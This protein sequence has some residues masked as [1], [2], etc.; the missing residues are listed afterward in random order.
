MGTDGETLTLGRA[1]GRALFLRC[2]R[3]GKGRIYAGW[4]AMNPQCDSC[5]LEFEREQGYYVGAMYVNYGLTVLIGLTVGIALM[6]RVPRKPLIISLGA[7][8]VLFPLAFFRHSRSFWLAVEQYI[9]SR[10]R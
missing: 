1:L 8:A 7:F 2:P 10:V 5:G 6:D 9:V 3:C 4:F